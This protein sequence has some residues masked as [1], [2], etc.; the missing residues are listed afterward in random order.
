MLASPVDDCSPP[1]RETACEQGGRTPCLPPPTPCE[2]AGGCTNTLV[3]TEA[4]LVVNSN[5]TS[6]IGVMVYTEARCVCAARDFEG[7]EEQDAA[8]EGVGVG[9]G[10]REGCQV[11]SC[12]NG[13]VCRLTEGAVRYLNDCDKVAL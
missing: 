1:P 12:F 4:P 10:G 11:N 5:R 13:G 8:G 7:D 2:G 6:L 9:R 3:I